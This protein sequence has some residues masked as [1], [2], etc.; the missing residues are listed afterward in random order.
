MGQR[1]RV[2][3]VAWFWDR[4]LGEVFEAALGRSW[5]ET[6]RAESR[7]AKEEFQCAFAALS[8]RARTCSCRLFFFKLTAG[9]ISWTSSEMPSGVR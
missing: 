4:Y 5:H 2:R 9:S 6:H 7:P 8:C 1:C 3:P